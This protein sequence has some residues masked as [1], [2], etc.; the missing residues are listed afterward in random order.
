MTS[1]SQDTFDEPAFDYVLVV[2]P[3]RS[4]TTYLYEILQKHY[5]V[6]FPEIKESYYYRSPRRLRRVRKQLSPKYTLGDVANLAYLDPRLPQ[7]VNNLQAEGI[8]V[9]LVV[10][11]RDHLDRAQSMVHF[12]ISRGRALRKGGY[13]EL[14]QKVVSRR[15]T[16]GQLDA[17][18]ATGLD[19]ATLD[20][21][22]LTTQPNSV[23]N[24]LA[25]LCGIPPCSQSLPL[26]RSNPSELARSVVA[27]AFASFLATGLRKVG[28][29]RTLQWL[30][31]NRWL[32]RQFFKPLPKDFHKSP[33]FAFETEQVRLLEQ[34]RN[35][36]WAAARRNSKPLGEGFFWA[37][38]QNHRG[39]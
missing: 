39:A 12:A 35:E 38:G 17:I 13:K 21:D 2:G 16:P 25:N 8:R 29:R 24:R 6:G 37:Q 32:H 5:A 7:A 27:A 20:Y 10:L 26:A 11:L 30:K 14:I 22:F 23:F 1:P 3:G 18:Y 4:G 31:G 9:L 19:V 33:A 36:C 28:L 34:T 15:L